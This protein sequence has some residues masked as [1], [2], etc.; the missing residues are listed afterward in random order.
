MFTK[1][2]TLAVLG[3]A[4]ATISVSAVAAP[5]VD[6]RVAP[7]ARAR[8]RIPRPVEATPGYRATGIGAVVATSG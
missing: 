6:V 5:Y 8:K 7:P 3:A 1:L 4:A 2:K